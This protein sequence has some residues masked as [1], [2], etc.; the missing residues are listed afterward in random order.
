MRALHVT[1]LRLMVLMS[2]RGLPLPKM[3]NPHLE[4]WKPLKYGYYQFSLLVGVDK[5][6]NTADYGYRY[7]GIIVLLALVEALTAPLS[8]LL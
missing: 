6:R 4:R 3:L 5:Q 1:G 8:S 2:R 7:N